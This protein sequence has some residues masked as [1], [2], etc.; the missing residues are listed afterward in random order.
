MTGLGGGVAGID[1]ER[2][3]EL[4][5]R[6]KG[7]GPDRRGSGY[8]ITAE[9]VLTAAHVV[10]GATGV[11]VRFDADRSGEWA[12]DGQV[13]W[14]DPEVDVAVVAIT[15]RPKDEGRV[16]PVGFGRVA[17][18]DAVLECS[19]MGF[20]LFK[21]RH[22]PVRAEG[23]RP[24]KY[25][26]S[27]HAVGTIAVLS[28]RREGTLEVS[29]PAPERDPDPQR[30]PWGGMSGAAVW[31]AGR[32]IGLVAEHHRSDGPGRLAATRVDG[33]RS[34]TQMRRRG[35]WPRWAER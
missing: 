9:A 12:A 16:E 7:Q 20:P 4:I 23:G 14:S 32:V 26:D 10:A 11:Q 13:E 30:S 25:R 19:A 33:A 21:L 31:S 8:R 15:P 22:D 35:R 18:R 24:S 3:A 1:P 5:V 2:V 27:V 28:N 6:T 34:P 17:E 29:V